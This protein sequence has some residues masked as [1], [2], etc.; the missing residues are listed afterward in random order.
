MNLPENKDNLLSELLSKNT[1]GAMLKS[2]GNTE[3]INAFTDKLTARFRVKSAE[4]P[5]V[6]IGP[7]AP[8]DLCDSVL[9]QIFNTFKFIPTRC[10]DCYKVVVEPK[11]V[12]Q[13]VKLYE[14]MEELQ[15]PS[16]CG[17]DAREYS[18]GNYLGTF[19]ARNLIDAN[20]IFDKVQPVIKKRVG[21]IRIYIK[22]FCS[23]FELSLC[24]NCSAKYKQPNGSKEIEEEIYK[25]VDHYEKEIPGQPDWLKRHIMLNWIRKAY[26]A[27]DET[28]MEF[29][30]GKHF[31]SGIQIYRE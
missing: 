18:F 24:P 15:L 30:G 8:D 13:L 2:T 6:H 17:W 29:N 11:T 5:W 22:R 20:M 19:Y 31:A 28:A 26:S 25:I 21:N 10:L 14:I 27:G 4:S 1:F 16:K 12:K 23:A 7:R 3:Y 9:W